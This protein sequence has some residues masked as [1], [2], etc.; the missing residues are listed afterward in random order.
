MSC[1]K[2]D[3]DG[4]N[5]MRLGEDAGF[6]LFFSEDGGD[7][8]VSI[9]RGGTSQPRR[10]LRRRLMAGDSGTSEMRVEGGGGCK[11][12]H[13][14][15]ERHCPQRRKLGQPGAL[16]SGEGV[17]LSPGSTGDRSQANR[18]MRVSPALPRVTGLEWAGTAGITQNFLHVNYTSIKRF[19]KKNKELSAHSQ[20]A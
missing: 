12:S 4:R 13:S 20:S 3:Y 9:C 7:F 14:T 15:G 17:R 8:A 11:R 19:L 5:E 6:I 10:R 2:L 18:G 1:K 16:L